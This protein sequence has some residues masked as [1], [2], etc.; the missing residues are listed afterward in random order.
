MAPA[1]ND[2][3]RCWTSIPLKQGK[4]REIVARQL[5][6]GQSTSVDSEIAY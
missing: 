3:E 4:S 6:V 2:N 5:G 1:V